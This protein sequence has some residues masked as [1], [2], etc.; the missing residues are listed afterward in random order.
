[1]SCFVGVSFIKFS[2]DVESLVKK[3]FN[4]DDTDI[5][6]KKVDENGKI[7][8]VGEG[9]ATI[10]V[11][12]KDDP[13]KKDTITVTVKIP[14]EEP[15]DDSV[16]SITAPEKITVYKDKRNRNDKF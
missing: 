16:T 9:E 3:T 4:V 2:V 7:T 5:V 6:I 15:E 14:V 13:T 12:S 10:T 8:A 11:T 1:M